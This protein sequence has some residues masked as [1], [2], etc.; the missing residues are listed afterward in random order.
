MKSSFSPYAGVAV[1]GGLT[2]ISQTGYS[3][4]HIAD[5]ALAV[6]F[7]AD[8]R[9]WSSADARQFLTLSSVN[10]YD[11]FGSNNRPLYF[12]V[13]GAIKYYFRP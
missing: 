2:R 10:S 7:G 8:I 11:L 6:N 1:K 5:I 3:D 12:N 9:I 4:D 13:G